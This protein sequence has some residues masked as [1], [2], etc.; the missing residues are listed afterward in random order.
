MTMEEMIYHNEMSMFSLKEFSNRELD[1]FYSL[2]HKIEAADEQVITISFK[3]LKSISNYE[4][5]SIQRFIK[6]LKSTYNKLLAVTWEYESEDIFESFHLFNSYKINK[7]TK[8]IELF[9]Q[10]ESKH[11]LNNITSH[12][13]KPE[14]EEF[15]N[16]TSSYAKN[17]YRLLNQ[18]KIDGY[19]KI[20]IGDFRN[21]L[22][23]PDT[24]RM[25]NISQR[26]LKPIKNELSSIFNNLQINKVKDEKGKG[27]RIKFIEFTFDK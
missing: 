23:I 2:C 20:E 5:G 15:C 7:E 6:D 3:E 17:M 18:S 4:K 16:L 14:L 26:V 25:T 9:V 10:R 11:L 8:T 22:G 12:F 27:G 24:Y 13:T 21:I 1:L 19:F